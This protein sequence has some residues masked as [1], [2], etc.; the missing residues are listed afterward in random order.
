MAIHATA[1]EMKAQQHARFTAR[2]KY[3]EKNEWSP[4]DELLL[5]GFCAD[6]FMLAP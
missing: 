3:R 6:A 4:G 1:R 5:I 2:C